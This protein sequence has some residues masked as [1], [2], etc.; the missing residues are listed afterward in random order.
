MLWSKRNDAKCVVVKTT[1]YL[2]LRIIQTRLTF[3]L[4]I[5]WSFGFPI[6]ASWILELALALAVR[7]VLLCTKFYGHS[8]KKLLGYCPFSFYAKSKIHESVTRHNEVIG[9]IKH[10]PN[11]IFKIRYVH[12]YLLERHLQSINNFGQILLQIN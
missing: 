12:T 10:V 11:T 6:C 9:N 5:Y 3:V 7:F 8:S 1:I 4:L 2:T